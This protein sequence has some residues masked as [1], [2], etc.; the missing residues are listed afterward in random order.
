MGLNLYLL[1]Q[2][3]GGN[4]LSYSY[5]VTGL[6]MAKTSAERQAEYRARR[7]VADSDERRLSTWVSS[8]VYSVIQ[9]LAK[10]YGVTNRAVIELLVSHEDG[11]LKELKDK[12]VLLLGKRSGGNAPLL[13]RNGSKE[14]GGNKLAKPNINK[15]LRNTAAEA[16]NKR[17]KKQ[18]VQTVEIKPSHFGGQFEL[19]L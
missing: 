7:A 1:S 14:V 18:I 12:G 5:A 17:R 2:L 11:R 13:R 4:V 6:A 10:R 15:L 8:D 9:Q 3:L 19:E 16:A